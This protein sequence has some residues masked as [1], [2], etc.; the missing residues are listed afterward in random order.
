MAHLD[1]TERASEGRGGCVQSLV[2]A[3]GLL[4]EIAE[5]EDGLTLTEVAARAE[6]P[7]S[8][9]HRLLTTMQSMSYVAFNT[10]TS[11]WMVGLRA[12]AVGASAGPTRDVARLA[13][14]LLQALARGAQV[15]AFVV[16]PAGREVHYVGHA[17]RTAGDPS[18]ACPG[19]RLDMHT[20]AAGKAILSCW[21]EADLCASLPAS[22]EPQRLRHE[23]QV[24]RRRG[25]AVD[26]PGLD[27]ALR[28]LAAPV[29]D[30]RGRVRAAIGVCGSPLQVCD[31]RLPALGAMVQVSARRLGEGFGLAVAA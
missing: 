11:R 21:D 1:T 22:V 14:P 30:R 18:L 8:T 16:T 23:L 28:C 19:D 5:R 6:L 4:D 10:S 17:Q 13:R 29:I 15:T 24:I 7:R 25:Y 9:A 20:T 3:L 27:P 12:I 31:A 2:R 26:D